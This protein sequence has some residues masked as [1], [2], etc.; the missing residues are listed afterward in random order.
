[1]SYSKGLKFAAVLGIALVG[2]SAPAALASPGSG[3]SSENLVTADLNESR[4]INS[5]RVKF[6]TKGRTNVR[7]Q[8]LT[9]GANSFS[10]WHHHPGIVIVAVQS[11]I[12]TLTDSNCGETSYGPGHPNGSVFVE[13]HDSAQ[14]ASSVAGAVVYVTY[15]APS[16]DPVDFRD[17]NDPPA[18]AL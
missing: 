11:G 12:V 17:E 3:I 7:V 18:C 5:D 15:V 4:H 16:A 14:Q 2:M 10:G 6:Q 8:K 9:F 1:M 13:G